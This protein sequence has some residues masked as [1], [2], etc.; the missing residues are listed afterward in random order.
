[1]QKQDKIIKMFNEIAPT[2]D[3]ANRILS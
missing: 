3:K 1:M 2:Y